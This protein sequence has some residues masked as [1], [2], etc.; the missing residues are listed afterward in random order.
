M[1]TE[2]EINKDILTIMFKIQAE[3]PELSKYIAEMPITIPNVENPEINRK[4]LQDYLN[5]LED[6]MKKYSNSVGIN[7]QNNENKNE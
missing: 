2:L 3:F 1:K 4:N 5:S 7:K 6:L